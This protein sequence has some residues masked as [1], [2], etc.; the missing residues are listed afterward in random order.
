LIVL[1]GAAATGRKVL[2]RAASSLTPTIMELSGCDAVVVIPGA[3]LERVADAIDFGLNFNSGATCIS[4]RRLIIEHSM[5]DALGKALDRRFASKLPHV[6][7]PA[8]RQ[9]AAETIQRA[10]AEGAVDRAPSFDAAVLRTTGR[11]R[12]L[13]LDQVRPENSIASADLFAP[14]TSMIRVDQI[15]EAVGIVNDCPYRLAASVFGPAE[16]ATKW[17]NELKVGSV[18]IN[19]LLF[20]TADPRLPFGGRGKS[21]FGVTRGV[22]GLLAM[23]VPK[24]ISRRSGR[25][26]LHFGEQPATRAQALQGALQLL[27]AGSLGQRFRGLKQMVS[28]EGSS[29]SR[30]SP[31]D[32]NSAET[33]RHL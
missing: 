9:A 21:G 20:P 24:V 6:V 15:E 29:K 16:P 4:P 17:A 18:A 27:H 3:D 33:E 8:A 14:V 28:A 22:E 7:H 23:T 25:F 32:E 30:N 11:M 13:V 5:A 2:E 1:T 26:A 31:A 10:I 19:D 12:P